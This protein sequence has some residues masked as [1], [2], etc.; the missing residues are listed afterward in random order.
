M[1]TWRSSLSDPGVYLWSDLQVARTYLHEQFP[2]QQ[3]EAA[4]LPDED[5]DICRRRLTT[6]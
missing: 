5:A 3:V 1:R 4:C 6:I 2:A